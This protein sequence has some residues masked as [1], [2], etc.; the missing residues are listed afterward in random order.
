MSIVK[1]AWLKAGISLVLWPGMILSVAASE[2]RTLKY[3]EVT[4]L[5]N[6]S[7]LRLEFDEE[8]LGDPVINFESGSLSLL[9]NSAKID[10]ALPFLTTIKKDPFIKAVRAVEVP[11]A[12][13][14]HLDILPNSSRVDLGH[15]EINHVGNNLMVVMPSKISP[16]TFKI[17][18]KKRMTDEKTIT[19]NKISLIINRSPKMP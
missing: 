7:Q 15:P 6:I 2:V 11:G 4:S 19:P 16:N 9:F 5:E 17:I 3:I 10:P 18:T 14:V 8:L 1:S 13:I 12:N